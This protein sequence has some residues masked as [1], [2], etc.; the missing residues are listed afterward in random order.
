MV[1]HATYQ[2][3]LPLVILEA[4]ACERPV[5]AS[6][7]GGIPEIVEDGR[8]G[9]LFPAG[10][11]HAASAAVARALDEPDLARGL[12]RSGADQVRLRCDRE[13]IADVMLAWYERTRVAWDRARGAEPAPA[14]SS[15]PAG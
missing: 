9:W 10:D 12:A 5:V 4:L 3:V 1:L 7:V 8:T 6:R 2:E 14:L 13:V 11:V 15:T